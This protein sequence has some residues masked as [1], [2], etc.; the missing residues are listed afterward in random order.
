MSLP[1]EVGGRQAGK[2]WEGRSTE[3]PAEHKIADGHHTIFAVRIKNNSMQIL[4][5]DSQWPP[6]QMECL[7]ERLSTDTNCIVQVTVW[8]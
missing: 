3:R 5:Q 1:N 4:E 2:T 6:W 7:A 8:P